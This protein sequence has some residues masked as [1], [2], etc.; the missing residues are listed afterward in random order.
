MALDAAATLLL[1]QSQALVGRCKGFSAAR[2]SRR[3]LVV[4]APPDTIPH[5]IFFHAPALALSCFNP[6]S[7]GRTR[8]VSV[9]VR[10][11]FLAGSSPSTR[12]RTPSSSCPYL[13]SPDRGYCLAT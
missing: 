7:H 10:G 4:A 8:L 1:P 6:P 13:A 5:L 11:G 2:F 3:H 9:T 12:T